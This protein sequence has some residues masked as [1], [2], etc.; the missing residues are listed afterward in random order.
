MNMQKRSRHSLFGVILLA[1]P[2]S[3]YAETTD[4]SSVDYGPLKIYAQSPLQSSSLTP[5]VRSGFSYRPDTIELYTSGNIA[6][7]WARTDDY[8]ADYYQNA[9]AIGGLWQ[10]TERWSLD[11]SY[12][13]RFAADNRLDSLTKD[14]HDLFGLS[15]NGR[16]EVDDHSFDIS[17]PKYGAEVHD[18]RGETLG[19][20]FNFYIGYQ[21][22]ENETHG[23]S[24]GGTLYYNYVGSGPFKVSNFEQSLQANYSYRTGKHNIYTL[25][26]VTYRHDDKVLADIKYKTFSFSSGVSYQYEIHPKHRILA[27]FHLYEGNSD[28]I[29]DLDEPSTEFLL[30]YRYHTRYGAIEVAAIENVFNMDNSTD[31][32]F[33]LGYRHQFAGSD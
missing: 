6:S 25:L 29:S 28:N 15:Q 2:F 13:W 3:S 7:V 8:L 4:N 19:N 22:L 12:T 5:L 30:G 20:A 11:A 9:L 26:G 21:V 14:F 23:L 1:M 27:E 16:D 32:A 18:F 17:A 10:L 33:S 31:I 24:L